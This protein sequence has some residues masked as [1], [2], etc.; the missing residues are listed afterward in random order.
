LQKCQRKCEKDDTGV[1]LEKEKRITSH[2]D[3]TFLKGEEKI[4]KKEKYME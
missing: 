3:I 2:K 1:A 4:D